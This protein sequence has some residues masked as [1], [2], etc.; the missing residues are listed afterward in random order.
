MKSRSAIQRVRSWLLDSA[1]TGGARSQ[2][3]YGERMLAVAEQSPY[4]L[5]WPK[6]PIWSTPQ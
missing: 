6:R 4:F 2:L 1:G 5:V 3:Q